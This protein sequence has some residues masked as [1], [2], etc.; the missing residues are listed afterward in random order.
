VDGNKS[1]PPA[2]R[3]AG[4]LLTNLDSPASDWDIGG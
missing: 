2:V 3:L 1:M 4:K